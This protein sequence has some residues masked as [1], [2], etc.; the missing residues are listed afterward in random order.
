MDEEQLQ[1][2]ILEAINSAA[3]SKEALTAKMTDAL[4]AE[5]TTLPGSSKTLG[6]IQRRME[7]LDREFDN[8]LSLTENVEENAARFKALS[9][10]M[11]SLKAQR[12]K[13]AAQLRKNSAAGE[14]VQNAVTA[15]KQM[16]HQLTEWDE[17]LIRQLVHTVKVVS[18]SHIQVCL[19]DGTVIEQE[20]RKQ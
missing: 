10:E 17:S 4:A 12:E 14:R 20:V 8:L 9:D 15:V 6:E 18:A 13:I 11:T 7:A 5:M 2:A 3:S 1:Q 16:N 19:M